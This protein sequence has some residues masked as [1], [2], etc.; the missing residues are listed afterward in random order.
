MYRKMGVV[1][2]LIV[3]L[4]MGGIVMPT[5]SASIPTAQGGG[6]PLVFLKDGDLWKWDGSVVTQLT[7][8]GYNERPVLSPNGQRV[9]YNSWAQIT[10]NAIAAGAA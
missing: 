10:I 8:W 2:G 6:A 5:A 4:L 7:T 1:L 3:T 9:A